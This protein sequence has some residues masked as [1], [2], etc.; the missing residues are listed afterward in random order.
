MAYQGRSTT[1]LPAAS[2]AVSMQRPFASPCKPA[3]S[4]MNQAHHSRHQIHQGARP[5]SSASIAI[6]YF[7]TSSCS[8]GAPVLLQSP[9]LLWLWVH[10]TTIRFGK[11]DALA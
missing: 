2:A 8:S 10:A 3:R 1:V 11:R 7:A 6:C 9:A 4:L 5:A